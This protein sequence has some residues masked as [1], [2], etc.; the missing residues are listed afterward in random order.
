MATNSASEATLDNKDDGPHQDQQ[1]DLINKQAPAD[2]TRLLRHHSRQLIR[3]LGLLDDKCLDIEIT[4]AQ[5]H[6]LI[7]L[8]D[9]PINGIALAERLSINKSN[10]S[11]TLKQLHSQGLVQH[12]QSQMDQRS[13]LS[14]LTPAGQTKLE[15][16][17]QIYDEFAQ[18]ALQ[19]LSPKES[20]ALIQSL[21][22]YRKALDQ[23][24]AQTGFE[25]RPIQAA[26][27]FDLCEVIKSVS[28]EH[29]LS[30]GGYAVSD[31]NLSQ[32]SSHYNQPRHAYWVVHNK[33]VV[34]G[35]GV[36]SLLGDPE[37]AELCKMYLLPEARGRGLARRLTCQA[38]RFAQEMGYSGLYLETTASLGAALKLYQSLGFEQLK[39]HRGNTG[40]Q[41]GCEIAMLLS[42]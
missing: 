15:A 30:G 42:F 33:R 40:H 16:L 29:G 4:P 20:E 39:T 28:A 19:Q 11:R 27:D 35:A 12:Q 1:H 8:E 38:I 2:Q 36:Q 9:N 5:A 14:H 26:D 7:E 10:A 18:A 31:A 32:L 22:H 21:S 6:A 41:S 3:A 25:L 23:S 17:H 13:Q 24:A 37:L 34:G